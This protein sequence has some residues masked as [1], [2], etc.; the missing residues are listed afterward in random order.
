M[1][2]SNF[3]DDVLKNTAKEGGILRK[4]AGSINHN[5][6]NFDNIGS[7]LR[8]NK[9]INS[10]GKFFMG[11]TADDGIRGLTRGINKGDSFKGALKNSYFKNGEVGLKN[12]KIG[13][14]AGT[15]VGA[16]L[17]ARELGGGGIYRDRTG[18]VNVPAVPF[19]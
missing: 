5:I 7:T 4:Y 6:E 19:I 10:I 13:A 1:N 16:S 8:S 14:M 18:R 3:F 17:V 15:Y 2:I 11:E 9:A 12:A